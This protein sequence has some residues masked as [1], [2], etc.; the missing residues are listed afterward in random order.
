MTSGY[1]RPDDQKAAEALGIRHIILKPSTIDALSQA[2]DDVLPRKAS[3]AAP[4]A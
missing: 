1:V 3:L 4:S 2:L